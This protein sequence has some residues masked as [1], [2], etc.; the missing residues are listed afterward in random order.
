MKGLTPFILI[1]AC[2]AVGFFY[3]NPQYKKIQAQRLEGLE[4][5]S[6]IAK[7]KEL[8]ELRD[9]LSDTLQSFSPADL[10]R[11]SKLLPEKV[12][13]ARLI[14]DVSGIASKYAIEMRDTETSDTTK[15]SAPTDKSVDKAYKSSTLSFEFQTSYEGM[16]QFVKDLEKSLRMVDVTAISLVQGTSQFPIY[17]YSITLQ[18]YWLNSK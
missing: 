12:D 9:S 7:S 14:L 2:I 17:D 5:D 1:L 18:A 13:T 10:E 11:I 15:S 6:V 3:I 8:K 4:Y 16:V